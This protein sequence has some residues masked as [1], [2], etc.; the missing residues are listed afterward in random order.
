MCAAAT[1]VCKEELSTIIVDHA[2]RTAFVGALDGEIVQLLLTSTGV[3]VYRRLTSRHRNF[4]IAK[5]QIIASWGGHSR[6][7]DGSVRQ[8]P[9]VNTHGSPHRPW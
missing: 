5:L 3:Q 6:T 8:D 2:G 9:E 1:D 7:K 4:E